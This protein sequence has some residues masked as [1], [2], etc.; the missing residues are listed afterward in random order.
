MSAI[1][2]NYQEISEQSTKVIDN[3]GR[4]TTYS[5]IQESLDFGFTILDLR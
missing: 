4:K 1:G 5:R 2:V 3:T